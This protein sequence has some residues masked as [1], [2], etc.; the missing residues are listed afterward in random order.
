MRL[1]CSSHR[2]SP[3][4]RRAAPGS[5]LSPHPNWQ[6]P[7]APHSNPPSASAPQ[8]PNPMR[9]CHSGWSHPAQRVLRQPVLQTG[10][11]VESPDP[12]GRRRYTSHIS[13]PRYTS[14]P[15]PQGP[16]STPAARPF[17]CAGVSA[18]CGKECS[19]TSPFCA[20]TAPFFF[21]L[22]GSDRNTG[23]L[24]SI[25]HI[26]KSIIQNTGANEGSILT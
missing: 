17:L 1:G 22:R 10:A 26:G 13:A 9:R 3:A 14:K 11:A 24:Q 18:W 16:G 20:D 12:H 23:P 5:G 25:Y 4:Y 21:C 15:P 8:P 7:R 6:D 19:Y 2:S